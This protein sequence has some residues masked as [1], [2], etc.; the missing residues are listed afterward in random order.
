MCK[1]LKAIDMMTVFHADHGINQP[2]LDYIYSEIMKLN[3]E[4]LFILRIDLPEELG[5]VSCGLHGPA[6]GDE[7][8]AEEEVTYKVRGDRAWTDRLVNREPRFVSYVQAI[9]IRRTPRTVQL[10]TC[11][12]G[13]LAP[14]NP[15]DPTNQD[16]DGAKVFWAEHALGN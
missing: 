3:V 16:V 15:N 13:P 6:M 14:Q 12:G 5:K 7:P 11:Y 4:G 8:I 10:F 2:H 1:E 9:G